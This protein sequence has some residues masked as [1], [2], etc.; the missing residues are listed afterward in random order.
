MT[1]MT[2]ATAPQFETAALKYVSFNWKVFPVYQ[3][4][5]NKNS[6]ETECSCLTWKRKNAKKLYG[7]D[8][9]E[10]CQS[11]GK[12]GRDYSWKKRASDDPEQIKRWAAKN[13]R[14]NI[15]IATGDVSGIVV[16]D[17]DGAEGQA[18]LDALTVEHGPLPATI[19][20]RTGSG[21]HHYY[22]KYPV[23]ENVSNTASTIAPKIDTRANGG[24]VVA[25]HPITRAVGHTSSWPVAPRTILNRLKCP[26]GCLRSR[27]RRRRV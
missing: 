25:P 26:N 1:S 2:L 13:P 24:F 23:G 18:S 15:G 4:V 10:P 12:H 5:S 19:T 11:P 14:S 3:I 27:R 22:F 20:V 17:I 9:V 8:D 21:G 7:E 6:G 16:L